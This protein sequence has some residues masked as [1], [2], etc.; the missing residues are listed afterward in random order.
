L[1]PIFFK[2][3]GWG[4]NNVERMLDLANN[5]L[6]KQNCDVQL[7]A[8]ELVEVKVPVGFEVLEEPEQIE[9]EKN[10]GILP[11]VVLADD[12]L[13]KS[14]VPASSPKGN[15]HIFENEEEQTEQSYDFSQDTNGL[16]IIGMGYIYL[17]NNL[18]LEKQ[19]ASCLPLLLIHEILHAMLGYETAQHERD[20]YNVFYTNC[21]ANVHT[22]ENTKISRQDCNNLKSY[23]RSVAEGNRKI[24]RVSQ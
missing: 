4:A 8:R 3:S 16:G 2:D 14:R 24:C 15:V 23:A 17:S 20:I 5:Y 9:L 6:K 1:Y 11:L 7:S 10:F 21:F 12:L 22:T 19:R 18:L 13:K